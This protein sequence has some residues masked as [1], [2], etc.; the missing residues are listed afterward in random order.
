M[1]AFFFSEIRTRHLKIRIRQFDEYLD[2]SE[3]LVPI[4]LVIGPEFSEESEID[5]ILYTANNIDRNMFLIRA[6]DL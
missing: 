5:A 1:S 3:K 2:A 4:F 6:E